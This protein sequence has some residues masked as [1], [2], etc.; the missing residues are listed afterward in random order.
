MEKLHLMLLAVLLFA[1]ITAAEQ[2]SVILGP[3]RVSFDLGIPRT[4]YTTEIGGPETSESLNGSSMTD[5]TLDIYTYSGSAKISLDIY[6]APSLNLSEKPMEKVL[7]ET[8]K[9]NAFQ[10]AITTSAVRQIDG[11]DGAVISIDVGGHSGYIAGYQPNINGS[12][13]VTMMSTIPWDEGTLSLLNT[14]HVEPAEASAN[15]SGSSSLTSP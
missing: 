1:G 6:D 5:Y 14:I 4:H 7:L 11:T 2:D 12:N 13:L 3:Y 10:G 8:A 9:P 15:S